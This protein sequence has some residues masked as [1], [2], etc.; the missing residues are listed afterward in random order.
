MARVQQISASALNPAASRAAGVYGAE[1]GALAPLSRCWSV[2]VCVVVVMVLWEP[3]ASCQLRLQSHRI[4]PLPAKCPGR[5]GWLRGVQKAR[6]HTH[7]LSTCLRMWVCESTSC[8]RALQH[9]HAL[10]Q[11][12]YIH[13]SQSVT[14]MWDLTPL[15]PSFRY[16]ESGFIRCTWFF[17][18]ITVKVAISR[19]TITRNVATF[20][21]N[22]LIKLV[23]RPYNTTWESCFHFLYCQFQ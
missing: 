17:V 14:L 1:S 5:L 2:S 20:A 21:L 23:S 11:S 10:S 7:D 4:Y 18:I 13:V 19:L 22:I 9:C 8:Q 12:P 3:Q 6:A 16:T 15:S